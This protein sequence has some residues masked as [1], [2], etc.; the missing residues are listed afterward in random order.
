MESNLSEFVFSN[1]NKYF[2]GI[3]NIKNCSQSLCY[4]FCN[5]FS[6]YCDE[7]LYKHNKLII[8]NDCS[9]FC[10]YSLYASN[11]KCN[12]N[13]IVFNKNEIIS[14]YGGEL[15]SNNELNVRYGNY[16]NPY[17]SILLKN[18]NN[19][20]SN[21]IIDSSLQHSLGILLKKSK[22]YDEINVEIIIDYVNENYEISIKALHNI[23]NNEQL[24]VYYNDY[25][26]YQNS[27][28]SINI[29]SED[30]IVNN[31]LKNNIINYKYVYIFEHL[32]EVGLLADI[33]YEK[34]KK[35]SIIQPYICDNVLFLKEEEY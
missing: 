34:L 7:C 12:N 15:I 30:Y 20:E 29:V 4:K 33:K 25:N 5:K 1:G 26:D 6:Y 18:N 23:K 8:L 31:Y 10:G 14:L 16:F 22:N 27:N 11:S 35:Y 2:C 3:I 13:S 32:I 17:I 9:N 21:I 24:I 28:Y 19:Y